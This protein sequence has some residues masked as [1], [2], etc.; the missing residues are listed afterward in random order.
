MCPCKFVQK[1][2]WTTWVILRAYF[3]NGH[4]NQTG[5][6]WAPFWTFHLGAQLQTYHPTSLYSTA[7]IGLPVSDKKNNCINNRKKDRPF[8]TDKINVVDMLAK[9]NT[10]LSEQITIN[11]ALVTFL[12]AGSDVVSFSPKS[13]R[14][15]SVQVSNIPSFRF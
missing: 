7:Y 11:N 13:D 6:Q 15:N 10:V 12:D 14:L 1:N 4:L 2:L 5:I 8:F 3:I 9:I